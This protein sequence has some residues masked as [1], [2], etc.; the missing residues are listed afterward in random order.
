MGEVDFELTFKWVGLGEVRFGLSRMDWNG[1]FSSGFDSL[2]W[3]GM[4][5]LG[6]D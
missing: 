3:I 6:L 1:K 2:E 4:G 5:N